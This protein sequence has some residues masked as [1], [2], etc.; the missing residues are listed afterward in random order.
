MITC[1]FIYASKVWGRMEGGPLQA[2]SPERVKKVALLM[3]L[4]P[5]VGKERLHL[6]GRAAG[7][8]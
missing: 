5:Q 2:V 4:K 3:E 8:R 7:R 1:C 6:R